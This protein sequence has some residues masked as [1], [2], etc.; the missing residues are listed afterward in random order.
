M[1][2]ND[3]EYPDNGIAYGNN[4]IVRT[5]YR[6]RLYDRDTDVEITNVLDS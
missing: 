4:I 1:T 5:A 6:R 3:T 2:L